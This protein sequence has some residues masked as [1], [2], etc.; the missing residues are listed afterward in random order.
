MKPR[1]RF[2]AAVNLQE[3]DRVPVFA[4]LTPQVAEKLGKKM[5]LPYAA[6]DSFLS[7]RISHTEILLELGN[8]AVGI[9][10]GR[11]KPTIRLEDGRLKDEFEII[12]QTVG[13]YDEA[14]VRPLAECETI[15]DLNRYQLPDPLAPSRFELAE[16]MVARYQENYAI[17]GDLEATIFELSWNLVGME[18][19]LM[20]MA[21]GK[22]Y[23]FELLDR[24]AEYN[25]KIGVRL[26]ELG[27]D[28]IW[29]GDDFGTQQG[30]MISPAMYRNIFKPRQRKVIKDFKEAN[31]NVK[32]AYHSCGSIVPIIE[33]LI[34]VG[35]DIL[36]PVQPQAKGMDLALFKEKFGDRIA[37]L[38][39][40]D[41]QG[42]LPNGTPA[43][44]EEEVK[45]RILAAGKGG[46]YV[47]APAHN[48]QPDT[49]LENIYAMY[50]AVKKYGTYPLN[51]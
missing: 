3:P 4:N 2:L 26:I 49:S 18:K 23:L 27:A 31:P 28:V 1:E 47:L 20:D 34:E 38:G 25:T 6:E 10:P 35:V 30:M 7:T 33:D 46:G 17:V 19:F 37:F 15:D 39:G 29:M 11:E 21:M 16:K 9:G 5:G 50:E 48:I 40:V 24:V 41:V 44:V 13:L 32:I 51:F 43:D 12:Y 14:V 42:V 45:Q 22:E 36:N 8:D